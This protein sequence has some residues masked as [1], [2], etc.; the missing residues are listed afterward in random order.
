VGYNIAYIGPTVM[1][2]LFYF[3][4]KRVY[5]VDQDWRTNQQVG[6]LVTFL[7]YFRRVLESNFVHNFTEAP[8]SIT[9]APFIMFYYWFLFGFVVMY[10]FLKPG[11][12]PWV[13][14]SD[15]IFIIL[16]AIFM[17]FEALN[18]S[19][20]CITAALRKPGSNT[21]G[22]PQGCG[23]GVVTVANYM[24]EGFAWTIFILIAQTWGSVMWMFVSWLAMYGRGSVKHQKYQEHAPE[25]AKGK[26]IMIPY[27]L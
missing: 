10:Y 20:H 13:E 21:R 1:I 24:W 7:H 26:K 8:Q 12:K 14:F 17:L 2:L 4:S 25:Y 11:Y 16:G 18:F 23:F 27:I 6:V 5:G 15:T 19:C 3:G 22:V 9:K